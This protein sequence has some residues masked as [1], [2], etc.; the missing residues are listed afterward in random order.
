MNRGAFLLISLKLILITAQDTE[1]KPIIGPSLK[2]VQ[3]PIIVNSVL[4]AAAT[5]RSSITFNGHTITTNIGDIGSNDATG[6]ILGVDAPNL[7][8][9]IVEEPGYV[10]Y[11]AGKILNGFYA[12][13]AIVSV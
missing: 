7:S 12:A 3:Q 8:S 1:W 6:P 9:D 11:G 2:T 13:N 4:N 5:S 10:G